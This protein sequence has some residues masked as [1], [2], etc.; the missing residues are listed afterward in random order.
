MGMTFF[1]R[2]GSVF[3]RRAVKY[4]P[5]L[6]RW[7]GQG[8][9]TSTGAIVTPETAWQCGAVL[10]C[11]RI[12][13]NM[14][15][16]LPLKVYRRIEGGKEP[17]PRHPVAQ[18][19]RRP[20]AEWTSFEWRERMIA[21][22]CIFGSSYNQLILDGKGVV[23][24]IW[25]LDA[26]KVK[27]ARSQEGGPRVYTYNNNGRERIF[28][29]DDILITPLLS[30]GIKGRSLIDL[31]REVIGLTVTAQEF[32]SRFFAND[33]TPRLLIKTVKEM[34]PEA[35]KSFL[36]AWFNRHGG[37]A[38][39][40]GVGFISGTDDIKVVDT[41]V[42]KLQ[43]VESRRFQLEEICRIF[44]VPLHLVQS[45]ERATNNNIEHQGIDFVTHSAN[46]W[47]KRIEERLDLSLF[48]PREGADYFCQFD[49]N[50]L[51]RGDYQSRTEGYARQ[52]A[53]GMMM[54]NE[55]RALENMNPV[56]NG[57]RL[58]IQGAM[59]PIEDAGRI[60][61]SGAIQ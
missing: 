44:G 34:G 2:L 56:P 10:A 35:R 46:P 39:A 24:E 7:L 51:M 37:A 12:L 61:A 21:D 54:P 6:E 33:A 48:G 19:L 16:Q 57:D 30:D 9:S 38:R 11:I 28:S 43:L 20:N 4:P 8:Y 31:A 42:S 3:S 55:A 13:A 60:P 29:E 14:A 45:L 47:L 40:H 18:V 58:F 50:G 26:S 41:D 32:A 27:V 1:Q 49:V 5:E 53:S 15:A 17:A 36:D 25:P 23:R 52:I 59:I 22:S